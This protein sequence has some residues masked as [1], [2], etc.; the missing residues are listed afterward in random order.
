MVR[1]AKGVG[2]GGQIVG[3]ADDAVRT[4]HHTRVELLRLVDLQGEGRCLEYVSRQVCGVAVEHHQIGERIV[5][6]FSAEV[7]SRGAGQ[8]VQT[9][10]ILQVFQLGFE[11]EVEA[12][13]QQ[14]AKGHFLLG[15]ATD[16]E[17]D[18]V[19]AGDGHVIGGV[20][21]AVRT[22]VAGPDTGTVQEVQAIGRGRGTA[23]HEIRRRGALVRQRRSAC[24][25]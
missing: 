13:T 20:Q 15:Q 5:L 25:G 21:N 11:D 2:V 18:G 17:V 16:P 7:E 24:D 8:I 9:V 19:Q 6:K 23:E 4:G 1:R 3:R 10:A 14:A 12:R 22:G